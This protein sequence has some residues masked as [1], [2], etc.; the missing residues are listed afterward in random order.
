M[1]ELRQRQGPVRDSSHQTPNTNVNRSGAHV[2]AQAIVGTTREHRLEL[3]APMDVTEEHGRGATGS[4]DE[5]Q[6]SAGHLGPADARPT[7]V[8]TVDSRALLDGA[9]VA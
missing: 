6:V 1:P 7:W 5:H 3:T 2:L 9:A 8:K 4:M